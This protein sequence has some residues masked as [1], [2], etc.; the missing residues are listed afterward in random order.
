MNQQEFEFM[1]DL[2]RA[3]ERRY[4]HKPGIGLR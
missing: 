1:T 2:A 4:P 3:F